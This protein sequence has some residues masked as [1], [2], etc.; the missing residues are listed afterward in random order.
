MTHTC[1]VTGCG[2]AAIP[3]YLM[4]PKHWRMVPLRLQRAVQVTFNPLQCSSDPS[5][6]VRP[7]TE[8]LKAARAAINY[9]RDLEKARADMERR[10]S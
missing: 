3:Q 9:V 10:G 6:R 7:S 2:A 4:C 8:W 1:H 5:K